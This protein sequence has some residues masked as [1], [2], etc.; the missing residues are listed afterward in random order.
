[1]SESKLGKLIDGD[2]TRDAIHIAIAP[3]VAGEKLAPGDHVGFLADGSVGESDKPIG[4]V[5]P[6]LRKVVKRGDPIWL[7]LYPNT[8]TSLRHQWA[9]PEFDKPTRSEGEQW[10]R[11]YAATV[12][13][14]YDE[15]MQAARDYVD[16]DEYLVHGPRFEGVCLPEEFWDHYTKVTNLPSKPGSFYSCSC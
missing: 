5:D 15:L 11:D 6:F 13:I 2:E 7:L 1:M 14:D 9:H 12:P 10:I 3:V 8:I 4:V 16:N